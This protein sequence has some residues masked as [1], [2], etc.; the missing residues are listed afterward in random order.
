MALRDAPSITDLRCIHKCTLLE[1]QQAHNKNMY[2]CARRA[3]P[4]VLQLLHAM[5][6]LCSRGRQLAVQLALGKQFIHKTHMTSVTMLIV[7]VTRH[8][9]PEPEKQ[10]G[11]K[12]NSTI[13]T[14]S[15]LP[16]LWS[17]PLMLLPAALQVVVLS[18]CSCICCEAAPHKQ[19]KQRNMAQ[20]TALRKKRAAEQPAIA[21]G[22]SS[23]ICLELQVDV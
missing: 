12:T 6:A 10:S 21:G 18:E 7:N 2:R 15:N 1:R 3:L 4:Q 22:K 13:D 16:A 20:S 23:A 11:V 5:H 14:R 19:P 17:A 9:T 8:S